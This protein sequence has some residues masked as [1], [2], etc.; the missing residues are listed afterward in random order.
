MFKRDPS[1]RKP[2]PSLLGPGRTFLGKLWRGVIRGNI[3]GIPFV[4]PVVTAISEARQGEVIRPAARVI[5]SSIT[6]V[7]MIGLAAERIWG[8]ATWN[9]IMRILS[10]I[11]F[12]V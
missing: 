5:S 11:L 12:G 7:V 10:R 8:D 6:I 2:K 9:D 3:D 4:G 1:G